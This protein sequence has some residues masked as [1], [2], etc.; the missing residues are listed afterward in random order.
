MG[1]LH[2]WKLLILYLFKA[3]FMLFLSP[4]FSSASKTQFYLHPS[5]MPLYP[6][7][8]KDNAREQIVQMLSPE[9]EVLI[10]IK[11]NIVGFF[12]AD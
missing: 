2:P 10:K 1:F 12:G 6:S 8:S 11:Q 3:I 4:S 9:K 5:V 7:V